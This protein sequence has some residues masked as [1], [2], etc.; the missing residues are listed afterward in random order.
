MKFVVLLFVLVS[1]SSRYLAWAFDEATYFN[2]TDYGAIGDGRT[3]S[4]K[5]INSFFNFYRYIS[6]IL[7]TLHH[8]TH[9][10]KVLF[11]AHL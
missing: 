5:V 11:L 3:E 8:F 6:M 4:S 9:S 10:F 1:S 7:Y 2:V